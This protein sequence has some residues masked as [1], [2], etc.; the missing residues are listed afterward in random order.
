MKD[1]DGKMSDYSSI[2]F[3]DTKPTIEDGNCECMGYDGAAYDV[4]VA[5]GDESDASG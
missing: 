4:A 3:E 2:S 1:P 5:S